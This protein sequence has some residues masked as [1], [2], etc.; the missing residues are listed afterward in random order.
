MQKRADDLVSGFLF[1]WTLAF[2]P[3]ALPME[4][5]VDDVE[6]VLPRQRPKHRDVKGVILPESMKNEERMFSVTSFDIMKHVLLIMDKILLD[7]CRIPKTDFRPP[8]NDY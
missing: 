7:H 8:N 1:Q 2:I 3:F 4:K 6:R 5:K